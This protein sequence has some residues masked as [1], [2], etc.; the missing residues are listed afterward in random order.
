MVAVVKLSIQQSEVK[1]GRL[2]CSQSIAVAK[3]RRVAGGRAVLMGQ[4]KKRRLGIQE[5]PKM[6]VGYKIL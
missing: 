4:V 5:Q 1:V 3:S 6:V 2:F